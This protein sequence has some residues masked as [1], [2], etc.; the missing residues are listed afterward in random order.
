MP[1]ATGP[2]F[3]ENL[4]GAGRP[5]S[6]VLA[7]SQATP[8]SSRKA[9]PPQCDS[10]TLSVPPYTY[11]HP[12]L[13]TPGTHSRSATGHNNHN[14]EPAPP[15][16]LPP[17]HEAAAPPAE[18]SAPGTTPSEPARPPREKPAKPPLSCSRA[19]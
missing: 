3:W 11:S 12:R 17:P 1:V 8:N 19:V 5:R 18:I 16:A 15:S 2:A 7:T 13:S 6:P 4:G 9:N 14:P 10:P